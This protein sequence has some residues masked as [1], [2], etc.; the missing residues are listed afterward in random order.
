[1]TIHKINQMREA[2]KV[3]CEFPFEIKALEKGYSDRILRIDLDKNEITTLPVSQQMKDLWTG[4]KGFDL[5]LMFQ[6]IDKNTKWDSPNNPIC[7]SPGPLGGTTSFPGSGKTLVTALSPI[8]QSAID[9]NVGGF[10]GPYLKFAGFDALVI[11]GKA[12]K[13]TIILLDAVKKKI[14]IES[15]PEESIDSHLVAEELTEMYADD[16]LD[17]RNIAVVSAGQ[18]ALHSRMG[19]LNFSFWDWRRNV[20]RLKQAGRGGVGTV[21][22]D[23]M[24]KALVIKN[25]DITPAW[26]V[27]ENKVAHLVNPK[28]ILS[29]PPNEIEIL[30]AIIEK[31]GNDPEYVI[32]MMQDIQDRFHYISLTAIERLVTKTGAHKAYL[33]HIATFDKFFSLEEKAPTSAEP[34][35]P[36]D[37][38]KNLVKQ[39]FVAL[40]NNAAANSWELDSYISRGGYESLKK[41][42]K[43]KN[44]EAIT[45]EVV[46]SGLR[47]RS[48]GSAIGPKWETAFKAKKDDVYIVC[49]ANE[50]GS[51]GLIGK[52]ILEKD[53]HPI[54]EGMMIAAYALGAK[55]GFI[56]VKNDHALVQE[57]LCQAIE[58]AHKKGFLGENIQ[59]SGFNFTL[60]IHRG[61]G[62]AVVAETTSLLETIA[63]RAG[64]A[65]AKYIPI[66]E[67][68]FRGKPT[69]VSNVETW[70]NI[71]VIIGKGAQW[72]AANRTKVLF[73][74][75][76]VQHTG[77]LEVPFGI[78]LREIVTEIGGGVNGGGKLKAVM[79]GG[80][81]GGIIPAD[82]L[83]VKID[84]E[85]LNE[86]GAN[87]GSG[88]VWV[89]DDKTCVVDV[90]RQQMEL[91]ADES[92]GKCT[93][94][95]E[96][97][98]AF[99]NTLNRI[100]RGE[101]K[102]NDIQ[103]L[104]EV[105]QTIKETSL[106][107]FGVVAVNPVLSSLRYF[108]K[109]YEDHI[110]NKK[111]G[112]GACQANG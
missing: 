26:R 64:D 9:C 2:H 88:A 56:V 60:H 21:F 96:G 75:G 47:G 93:P 31:W 105:S 43:E 68:G 49:S 80:P 101:G 65:H 41:V 66:E 17:K 84:F 6:E 3:L 14:T 27:E 106:C 42:L 10:F 71:P 61:A 1:M 94:C 46:A 79:V 81:L 110:E 50:A 52:Y 51:H 90:V 87:M 108:K 67:A 54:I 69:I 98:F 77:L 78:T 34:A 36:V 25:R 28:K 111:C 59:G 92:C 63:G 45:R 12:K 23:K 109:E 39:Q 16:D 107:N 102:E 95:R 72:A 40:R 19:V 74:S 8:T 73:L 62:T 85:A 33:Y 20:T 30:D 76:N 48:C 58:A 7:F 22:R 53:P 82:K 112:I 32:E 83:D 37:V 91:L 11:V 70:T 104:D 15:A 13:E 24:L 103:F 5:W 100:C 97:L 4:G 35:K 57:R 38:I 55:E 99:K 44:P 86:A 18:A 29:Q 89:M